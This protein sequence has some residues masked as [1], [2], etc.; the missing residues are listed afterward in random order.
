[1]N[2][3]VGAGNLKHFLLFLIYTWS[4]SVFSLILLGYNYFFCA[5]EGC[6][7]N[8]VLTQLVRIMTILSI[9]AFLFTSS[10]L[11]NVVYG[12]MTGVG[13]IDRLKKK[14]TGT[15]SDADED[16]IPLTDVFGIG[17]LYQWPLPIDPMFDDYDRVMGYATPQRL[18]REQ[19]RVGQQQQQRGKMI[20]SSV[21]GASSV[22]SR[23]SYMPV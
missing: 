15:M 22:V 2:N 4:C 21:V 6:V 13:T 8:L 7:F 14:A 12:I 5:D 20:A 10:M 11:M 23:D 1:M 16:S 9:G 3:C 17:A 18:L 19:M